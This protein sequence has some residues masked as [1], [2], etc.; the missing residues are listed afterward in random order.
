MSTRRDEET[1]R[2]GEKE[3]RTMKKGR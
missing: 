3:S 1:G 2:Q